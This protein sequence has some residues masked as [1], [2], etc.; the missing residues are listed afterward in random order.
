MADKDITGSGRLPDGTGP[1]GFAPNPQAVSALP[2]ASL[3]RGG[4]ECPICGT[5]TPHHHGSVV[6]DAYQ[7]KGARN[8]R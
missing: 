4:F 6:V 8:A 1:A 3:S 5:A 7:N 2:G